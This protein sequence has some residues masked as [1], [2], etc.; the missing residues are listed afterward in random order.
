MTDVKETV[1]GRFDKRLRDAIAELG[2]SA[3]TPIQEKAIPPLLEGRDLIGCAQTGTGKTAAFLLP[4]IERLADPKAQRGKPG[5]PRALVLSPTRELAAQT[6]ENHVKYSK[7]THTKYACVFGGVNQYGQ[8]KDIR[9]GAEIV[10]A[11]P[12]RLIDLMTQG[13][14]YLDKVEYFVLDEADRMLDMGFLPD[15]RRVLSKLPVKK[16]SMFFSATLSPEILKLAGELVKDPVQVMISPET[17]TVDA[18]NQK[19][20]CVEKNNKDNLLCW[21]LE[22]NP[23]WDKVIVFARTRHGADRVLKKLMK[24]KIA[25]A[26][27]HS[28]KTQAQRTRALSG[29]KSGKIRVLVATDIASRG[30]DVPEVDLV[31]QMELPLETESYVHRIGRTA[32]AGKGG[33]AIGFVAPEER[34]LV[35]A[36][37]RYIKK[38]IPVDR[39]HPY[40]VDVA[41]KDK[42]GLPTAPGING[43]KFRELAEEGKKGGKFNRRRGHGRRQPDFGQKTRFS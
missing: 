37:E 27:I 15:I 36:V 4:I 32:R 22:E 21:L 40:H 6:C 38:S 19:L 1:F 30:I 26:A 13:E 35:K 42:G 33:A 23:E 10:I 28:D 2:Y 31:V 3:P 12:G 43:K 20:M 39:D 25:V 29:F 17:P 16:Q 9:R 11:T 7:Y 34:V 8:V 41:G 24:K 14:V 5:H 18:I